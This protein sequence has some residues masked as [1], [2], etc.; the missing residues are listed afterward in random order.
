MQVLCPFFK[1]TQNILTSSDQAFSF[2]LSNSGQP[3]RTPELRLVAFY[4]DDEAVVVDFL[5]GSSAAGAASLGK[6]AKLACL[7]WLWVKT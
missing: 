2:G 7:I 4:N 5:R 1:E 6:A 3:W